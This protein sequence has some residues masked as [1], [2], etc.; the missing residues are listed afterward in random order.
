MSKKHKRSAERPAQAASKPVVDRT[1]P[2]AS[3]NVSEAATLLLH[4][5]VGMALAALGFLLYAN[6]LGHGYVLDDPLAITKHSI[7]QK[8]ISAIPE[9]LTTHYRMGTEGANA[10]ALLYRPLSLVTFAIE[11]S[12]LPNSSSF[13]HF[14][15]VLWY[16]L[17]VGV[18]FFAL[19]RTF[20]GYHWVWAAMSVLLFA[21]HPLHTEVVANIKSRDE[22][23][24][25]F[26]G[27]G[28]LY[29]WARW[30]EGGGSKWLAFSLGTYWLA[31]LSKESAATL[32][33]VFP[34]VGWFFYEKNARQ[35]ALQG[36]WM[37]L[38]V[39]VFMA[40]RTLAFA[41]VTATGKIDLMDNPIVEADFS[42]RLAMGFSVLARYL[43]LL[44][45]PHTLL[46]DYSYRHLPLQGW[47]DPRA[48]VG[49]ATY[50]AIGIASIW[51]LLRRHPLAFCGL[52]FLA[53]I[54]LY[55]QILMV[56]GTL[57]GERLAYAPSLWFCAAVAFGVL[58]LTRYAVR[59]LETGLP[60]KVALALVGVVAAFFAFQTVR[61]N[62]DWASNFTLFAADSPKA[63][64]SVRLHN[65]LSE[66]Y[67]LKAA[68]ISKADDPMQAEY[69]KQCVAQATQ[70]LAIR[71]T[72]SAYISLGNAAFLQRQFAEG[73][74]QYLAAIKEAPNFDVPKNNLSYLYREWAR[75]EGQQNNNLLRSAELFERFLQYGTPDGAVYG[76]LGVVYGR[77]G[78]NAKAM[79]Y[80][81]KAT[82]LNPDNKEAWRNLATAYQAMGLTEKAAAALQRAGR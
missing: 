39:V 61:R 5:W 68:E 76:D 44:L 12:L 19:R 57:F 18:L 27:A 66:A 42:T 7:V 28:A 80:F 64:N 4:R 30:L 48:L 65:G 23:L 49:L 69:L 62:P 33:P 43:E 45:V 47:S 1:T 67:Y 36:L 14:M 31:L 2:S 63:P 77:L 54:V 70:S 11:H 51:G 20:R 15:N 56:I 81:E 52:A 34:L 53:S 79:L 46:S 10:S 50:T 21:V 25:V 8:G 13:G 75:W 40:M 59:R 22:I 38:P 35:S 73:E 26:F 55:S 3:A 41:K 37:L 17:S 9:L 71:P 24:A 72:T 78:D 16:A 6:T 74:K 32:W 58:A 29:A 60:S 82:Q